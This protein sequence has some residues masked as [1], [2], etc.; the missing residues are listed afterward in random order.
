MSPRSPAAFVGW[1]EREFVWFS[2]YTLLK[3]LKFT[4]F[5]KKLYSKVDLKKHINLFLKFKIIST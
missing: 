5:L 1:R 3:L 4:F 2:M